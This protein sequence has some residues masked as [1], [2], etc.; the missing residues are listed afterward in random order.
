MLEKLKKFCGTNIPISIYNDSENSDKC[1]LGYVQ[2]VNEEWVLTKEISPTGRFDGY[3]TQRFE[4]IFRVEQDTQYIKKLAILYDL[5][6][7]ANSEFNLNISENILPN[8]LDSAIQNH[9]M[10]TTWVNND[11]GAITGYVTEYQDGV[12]SMQQITEYGEKD[13]LVMIYEEDIVQ[14]WLGAEDDADIDKLVQD[15]KRELSSC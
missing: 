9:I 14:V 1:C 8:A 13:G 12:V 2:A 15:R 3:C 6:K 5:K 11:S 7:D 4:D 10:T